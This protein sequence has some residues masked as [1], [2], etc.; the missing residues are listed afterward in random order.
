MSGV[1]ITSSAYQQIASL[2]RR[3]ANSCETLRDK[4]IALQSELRRVDEEESIKL[5]WTFTIEFG[6][7]QKPIV[8]PDNVQLILIDQIT[9]MLYHEHVRT[10][11]LFIDYLSLIRLNGC[12]K[13]FI[14]RPLLGTPMERPR[15]CP[16]QNS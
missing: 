8:N 6:Y 3:S 7:V 12:P 13:S 1:G 10:D 15:L 5:H 9:T 14:M 4:I 2:A 11:V 16:L